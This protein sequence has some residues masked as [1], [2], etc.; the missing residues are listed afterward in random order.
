[1]LEVLRTS[2]LGLGCGGIVGG[3]TE[4]SHA[5]SSEGGQPQK[6]KEKQFMSGSSTNNVNQLANDQTNSKPNNAPKRG[7]G[8]RGR[9]NS[10]NHKTPV[11]QP[12]NHKNHSS[13]KQV[14]IKTNYSNP[15]MQRPNMYAAKMLNQLFQHYP[16]IVIEC[17]KRMILPSEYGVPRL[18]GNSYAPTAVIRTVR[19]I[20][21]SVNFDDPNPE[22]SGRFSGV[23]APGLGVAS[24]NPIEWQNSL[25]DTTLGFPLNLD[26][27]AS[28]IRSKPGP[29]GSDYRVDI[30]AGALT[31]PLLGVN[32]GPWL[33]NYGLAPNQAPLSGPP[34]YVVVDSGLYPTMVSDATTGISTWTLP[35]GQYLLTLMT[36]GPQGE[37]VVQ[38][39]VAGTGSADVVLLNQYAVVSNNNEPYSTA[40]YAVSI[41]K[42]TDTVTMNSPYTIVINGATVEWAPAYFPTLAAP[43]PMNGGLIEKL[44]PTSC[45]VLVSNINPTAFTGGTIVGNLVDNDTLVE[46]YFIPQSGSSL[47]M[48]ENLITLP[49]RP[50]YQ[51]D[52]KNGTYG[53]YVPLDFNQTNFVRPDDMKL[54][55]YPQLVVSGQVTR[56]AGLTGVQPAVRIQVIHGYEYVTASQIPNQIAVQGSLEL[57]NKMVSAFQ[58][59]PV[60]CENPTH[61][62]KVADFIGSLP[63][64]VSDVNGIVKGV[65][66]IFGT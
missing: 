5:R 48:Y 52:L 22:N 66:S 40:E 32:T 21:L 45:S 44:R 34:T 39:Q 53:F 8:R 2:K 42:T 15:D 11:E 1:M 16:Q 46:K 60:F 35:I 28:Y 17:I 9:G 58:K 54:V 10:Q 59:S 14:V 41:Y 51:G 36:H 4:R 37:P 6:T 33:A 3:A 29:L 47:A 20:T 38:M 23:F 62:N 50:C 26:Q 27:P 49:G 31:Q 25:V 65:L 43:I 55:G 56:A 57:V 63:K 13:N 19:E 61:K 30:Q 64:I 12:K 7:S 24:Q 18:P